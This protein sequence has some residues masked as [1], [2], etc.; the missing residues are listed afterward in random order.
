MPP[1]DLLLCAARDVQECARATP[2][3]GIAGR[4]YPGSLEREAEKKSTQKAA[5]LTKKHP[6]AVM[7][8][9]RQR[10]NMPAITVQ[11][12]IAVHGRNATSRT[13]M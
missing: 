8:R 3:A 2:M 13:G 6:V 11:I 12:N 7:W 5:Q 10:R 4:T 9:V 1:N